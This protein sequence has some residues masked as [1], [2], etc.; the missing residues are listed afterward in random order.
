MKLVIELQNE[1]FFFSKNII[2][3]KMKNKTINNKKKP[4]ML[5][6]NLN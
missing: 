4:E 5:F 2:N 3:S 6:L 1:V